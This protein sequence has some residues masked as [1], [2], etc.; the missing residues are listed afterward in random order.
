M[1]TIGWRVLGVL[2]G[3][4]ATPA[5]EA[6]STP[7]EAMAQFALPEHFELQLLA[8]EPDIVS[9][10]TMAF[11]EQGRLFVTEAFNHLFNPKTIPVMSGICPVVLLEPGATGYVRQGMVLRDQGLLM[12]MTVRG[13]KIYVAASN[14]VLV[15]ELR[16]DG[17]AG[18][19]RTLITDE[20]GDAGTAGF[21]RLKFGPDGWL[22]L[23]SGAHPAEPA[24]TDGRRVEVSRAT[25]AIFRFRPDGSGLQL[26]CQ[27]LVDP[28]ECDI[29]PFGH[30]W[31]ASDEGPGRNRLIMAIPGVDYQSGLS[32]GPGNWLAQEFAWAPPANM[33][34][35]GA[36]PQVAG[37]FSNALPE[38]YRG[39]LMLLTWSG[40]SEEKATAR[41]DVYHPDRQGVVKGPE[42][43]LECNDPLFQP[44]HLYI[45]PDGNPCVVD[46][47][48][49][50]EEETRGRI[51]R[52][53]YV[54]PGAEVDAKPQAARAT[55]RSPEDAFRDLRSRNQ[56]TRQRAAQVLVAGADGSTVSALGQLLREKLDPFVQAQVLWTLDGI[57]TP[58]AVDAITDGLHAGEG[59]IRAMA[60]RI[61]RELAPPDLAT[62]LATVRD[63]TDAET[64]IEYALGQADSA[65]AVEQLQA[66]LFSPTVQAH[67]HRR[68]RYQAAVELS[69]RLTADE[70]L[71]LFTSREEPKA[72][73][74][75]IAL[76][77]GML[78]KANPQAAAAVN[79]LLLDPPPERID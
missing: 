71:G 64:R 3:V 36:R 22:Y 41:I 20:W 23:V 59:A 62:R 65:K 14:K 17:T 69:R 35:H 42:P 27:G 51:Y 53:A 1:R 78:E 43:F 7:A 75:A 76:D 19:P 4:A 9:P 63:D 77:V 49:Q 29:D 39:S 24:G 34:G 38:S 57:G 16:P 47:A 67:Q 74:G 68:L 33:V 12:G 52:V 26:V 58:A 44:A 55:P 60:V 28:L 13:G 21:L 45:D 73:I 15:A 46:L 6:G 5:P 10:L 32:M 48:G 72:L 30:V 37:Y 70:F 2:C 79:Q 66:A 54:G 50:L 61:L 25:G 56:N 8:C 11:D 40:S 31:T 18:P